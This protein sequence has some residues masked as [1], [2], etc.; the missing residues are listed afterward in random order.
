[1]AGP[2]ARAEPQVPDPDESVATRGETPSAVGREGRVE[3]LVVVLH[4][5]AAQA[6]HTPVPEPQLPVAGARQNLPV[7]GA[8]GDGVNGF[9]QSHRRCRGTSTR[10]SQ[11]SSARRESKRD[12]VPVARNRPSRDSAMSATC[13]A[14]IRGKG[15]S[16]AGEVVTTDAHVGAESPDTS[17]PA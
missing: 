3:D 4:R 1:M 12:E 15:R 9:G 2:D 13:C 14:G 10:S 7:V 6:A 8:E 17:R 16:A 5:R 11:T